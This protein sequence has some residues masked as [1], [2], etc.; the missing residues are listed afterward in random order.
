MR[1]HA[2]RPAAADEHVGRVGSSVH[3]TTPYLVPHPY[4]LY[5]VKPPW[6]LPCLLDWVVIVLYLIVQV[7][8]GRTAN[9]DVGS[10]GCSVVK[11]SSN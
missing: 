1:K 11:T 6:D 3:E 2:P 5:S 10:M 8:A 4:L 9:M 7:R